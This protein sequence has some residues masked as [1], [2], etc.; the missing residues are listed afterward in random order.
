MREA[1][2][3]YRARFPTVEAILIGT[4]RADPHGGAPSINWRASRFYLRVSSD[5]GLPREDRSRLATIRT[6]TPNHQLGL[7][8]RLDIPSPAQD[9]LL[10]FV[11]RGVRLLFSSNTSLQFFVCYARYTSL[12]STYNT[13]RNPALLV[14]DDEDGSRSKATSRERCSGQL[15]TIDSIISP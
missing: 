15:Y 9:T 8:R 11:R 3:L 12:G 5:I 13:F 14:C 2:E 7:R 6:R 4:R 1:L 10:L